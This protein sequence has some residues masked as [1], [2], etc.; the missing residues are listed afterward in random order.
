MRAGD[1][2]KVRAPKHSD[3]VLGWSQWS[4]L[5]GTVLRLMDES[6]ALVDIASVD[7]GIWFEVDHLEPTAR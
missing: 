5:E 3:Q 6:L 1:R 2:V 4:G 7:G